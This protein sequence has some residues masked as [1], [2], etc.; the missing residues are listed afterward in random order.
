MW[1]VRGATQVYVLMPDASLWVCPFGG[2]PSRRAS[3]CTRPIPQE[4]VNLHR[5]FINDREVILYTRCPHGV[6]GDPWGVRYE[7]YNPEANYWSTVTSDVF[8]KAVSF[9]AK[10]IANRLAEAALLGD[11]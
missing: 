6:G 10:E 11:T 8:F 2:L 3:A 1:A 4:Y 9:D 7:L 5:G